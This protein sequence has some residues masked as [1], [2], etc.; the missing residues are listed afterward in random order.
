MDSLFLTKTIEK[1]KWEENFK[2]KITNIELK[3]VLLI[4][5][6]LTRPEN[7]ET[8]DYVTELCAKCYS[9][10]KVLGEFVLENI[11]IWISSYNLFL[12][13]L[14]WHFDDLIILVSKLT[15]INF[16]GFNFTNFEWLKIIEACVNVTEIIFHGNTLGQTA[17]PILSKLP[18]LTHL[19]FKRC[20]LG[21]MFFMNFENLSELKELRILDLYNFNG[22][23]ILPKSLEKFRMEQVKL[24]TNKINFSQAYNLEVFS[25]SLLGW[26]QILSF[27]NNLC[28][29]KITVHCPSFNDIISIKNC[30]LIEEIDLIG[31][32][33]WDKNLL[34][35]ESSE[36]L[37]KIELT[38][39]ANFKPTIPLDLSTCKSLEEVRLFNCHKFN[40]PIIFTLNT[41]LKIF[42][43]ANCFEFNQHVNWELI[44]N[45]NIITNKCH[46]M[47]YK[48]INLHNW[49][50]KF[51]KLIE[52]KERQ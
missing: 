51:K 9:V 10:D 43:M 41:N 12:C 45:A 3:D 37:K 44:P 23:I 5:E 20:S 32:G 49:Q 28:L 27:K 22:P 50:D 36:K 46:K 13:D 47:R 38:H 2:E 6:N 7:S 24:F 15:K 48:P 33:L 21:I 40:V 52:T 4:I 18:K 1:L 31:C 14:R 25:I 11:A 29:R 39:C 30:R 17:V 19:K 34:L 35:P 16:Y 42:N 26:T 8:I